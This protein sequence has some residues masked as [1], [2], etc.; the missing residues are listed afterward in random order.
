MAEAFDKL[1][2]HVV[3]GFTGTTC[4]SA[5]NAPLARARSGP[6]HDRAHQGTELDRV[7]RLWRGQRVRSWIAALT[8][9]TIAVQRVHRG[10]VARKLAAARRAARA[11]REARAIYHYHATLA[12]RT[13]RGFYSRRY[14]HDFRARRRYVEA[15]VA[16]GEAL[17]ERLDQR[18]AARELD[19]QAA[20]D[21]RRAG[22]L[23]AAARH[24]HHLVSTASAPGVYAAPVFDPRSAPTARGATMETHLRAGVRGALALS[25]RRYA[26][27]PPSSAAS[28]RRRR[29]REASRSRPPSPSPIPA[30]STRYPVPRRPHDPLDHPSA[31]RITRRR[32][33]ISLYPLSAMVGV[34]FGHK[35]SVGSFPNHLAFPYDIV[36]KRT[37]YV[38]TADIP[39]ANRDMVEVSVD[40]DRV[41]H[42]VDERADRH[43][44]RG[45]SEP[46]AEAARPPSPATPAVVERVVRVG[47]DDGVSTVWTV[48][49][50]STATDVRAR[51]S[52][53]RIHR[54]RAPRGRSRRGRARARGPG[55]HGGWIRRI[56]M[57]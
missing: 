18:R 17:R 32:P 55:R 5:T 24:L 38:I 23:A 50:V 43:E 51:W 3:A 40:E 14:R 33:S 54:Q 9:A 22:A 13:F 6:L 53:R 12:Q 21:A 25:R 52:T 11:R 31:L 20:D 42:V 26:E 39:G 47:R 49:T 10:V 28:S 57:E 15:V 19:D 45:G 56:R 46:G 44:E 36:D 2:C 8:S 41:L 34:P 16:T 29:G 1:A 48:W 7:Q 37:E 4:V 30:R 27:P 35:D